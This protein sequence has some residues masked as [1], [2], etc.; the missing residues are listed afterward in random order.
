MAEEEQDDENQTYEGQLL[1]MEK[2][3]QLA[4]LAG[5]ELVEENESLQSTIHHLEESNEHERELSSM[6]RNEVKQLQ[7]EIKRTRVGYDRAMR[8]LAEADK[9]RDRLQEVINEQEHHQHIALDKITRDL[10]EA[11]KSRDDNDKLFN[12]HNVF[13]EGGDEEEGGGGQKNI[14]NYMRHRRGGLNTGFSS[15]TTA[16]NI[17]KEA[18]ANASD[19]VTM[20]LDAAHSGLAAESKRHEKLRR[21]NQKGLI[22]SME[23]RHHEAEH[24]AAVNR[25]R[26]V[27]KMAQKTSEKN[28]HLVILI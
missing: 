7:Y 5:L 18:S 12:K 22:D 17:V 24:H 10:Q 21:M 13:S 16:S 28:E 11:R 9:E 19:H 2:Q 15:I 14:T 25:W 1:E 20:T 6:L 27:M 26:T 4:G 23:W 8:Q 3:L